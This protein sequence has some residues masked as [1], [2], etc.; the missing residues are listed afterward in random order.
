MMMKKEKSFKDGRITNEWDQKWLNCPNTK[1]ETIE[2]IVSVWW[3][4]TKKEGW[5]KDFK[6]LKGFIMILNWEKW[7]KRKRLFLEMTFNR[8]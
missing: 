5:K 3:L 4:K 7:I 6:V 8:I 2:A 1:K